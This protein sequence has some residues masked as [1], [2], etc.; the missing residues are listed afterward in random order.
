MI[1]MELME[2]LRT[3]RAIRE[4][5]E[6]PVG[7][8]TLEKL[9]KA[10]VWAPSAMNLQPWAF[11]VV[12]GAE[13][14]SGCAAEAKRHLLA[15]MPANSPL[16]RYREMLI[17]PEFHIFYHAPALVVVCATT[18]DSQSVE[19]CCLAAQNLMLAAHAQGLGSCWIGFSRPWLGLSEVKARLDIPSAYVPVAPLV[20]GH[21]KTRPE[22]THRDKPKIVWCA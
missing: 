16:A 7:R 18:G 6:K 13:K 19:D 5:T 21:P 8:A 10:A 4:Y 11:A 22:P 1:A 2:A 3:R 15:T 14:L 9:I 20:V 12:E 17:D